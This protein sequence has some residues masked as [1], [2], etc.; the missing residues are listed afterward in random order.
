[1]KLVYDRF[2]NLFESMVTR[3]LENRNI[4]II[5]CAADIGGRMEII[6]EYIKH[7]EISYCTVLDLILT[8][9]ELEVYESSMRFILENFNEQK[10]YEITGCTI[11]ELSSFIEDIREI[12]KKYVRDE[13][14]PSKYESLRISKE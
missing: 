7:D 1:M 6:M 8:Q 10:I 14:L 2:Y 4:F 13:V 9:D 12:F 3:K 5:I 11:E